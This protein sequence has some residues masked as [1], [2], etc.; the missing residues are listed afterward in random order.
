MPVRKRLA[1]MAGMP[2]VI[3]VQWI[4]AGFRF[5]RFLSRKIWAG[6]M[7]QIFDRHRYIPG[8]LP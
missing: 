4:T 7:C 8:L 1:L 3:L 5:N 2:T 6:T